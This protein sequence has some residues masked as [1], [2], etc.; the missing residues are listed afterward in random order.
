MT[1]PMQVA[2]AWQLDPG[3]QA[4][5]GAPHAMHMLV[6]V[7]GGSAQPSPALQVSSSQQG[8]PAPPQVTQVSCAPMAPP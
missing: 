3:Q 1:A 6:S 5:P 2:P 8:W 4:A 7:P